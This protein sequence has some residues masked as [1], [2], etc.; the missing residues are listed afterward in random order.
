MLTKFKHSVT[1]VKR[2]IGFIKKEKPAL[3][4]ENLAKLGV[5]EEFYE[6]YS[7]FINLY[8]KPLENAEKSENTKEY[9]SLI[10]NCI[11]LYKNEVKKAL[12]DLMLYNKT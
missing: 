1:I 6:L 7:Y 4:V 12:I 11:N 5:L 3:T 10:D 9:Y 8:W 2:G